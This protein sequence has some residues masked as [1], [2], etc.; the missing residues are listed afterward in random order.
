MTRLSML[1]KASLLI[2]F[3]LFWADI[4][5]AQEE[6]DEP[7]PPPL[8]GQ[9]PPSF[10]DIGDFPGGGGGGSPVVRP[11]RFV[12]LSTLQAAGVT[13]DE[14]EE[15]VSKARSFSKE[16]NG[17]YGGPI[18]SALTGTTSELEGTGLDTLAATFGADVWANDVAIF[19]VMLQGD[20]AEQDGADGLDFD[21]TGYMAGVYGIYQITDFTFDGRI[22]AGQAQT[23][24][25]DGTDTADGV[26]STRWLANLQISSQREFDNGTLFVPR[27][28][29]GY[30]V[31][32]TDAYTLGASDVEDK[33]IAYGQADIGSSFLIPFQAGGTDGNIVAGATGIWAFGEDADSQVPRDLR[34]RVDLG[35]ELFSANSW[36]VSG[37]VFA[38]GVGEEDF[39]SF[40]ADLGVMFWF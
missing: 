22:L 33:R 19:G 24:I 13:P 37:K 10:P 7:D 28:A 17:G 29:L 39:E 38:D 20:T 36:S 4:A 11:S 21:S 30:L 35:V 18:W 14:R 1:F 40:G 23:D 32:D 6:P 2:V 16:D 31:D 27:V 25:T 3:G 8:Q 15:I 5:I 34:G 12:S 9:I 26:D